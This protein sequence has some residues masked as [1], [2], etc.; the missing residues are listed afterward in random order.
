MPSM[1]ISGSLNV[2]SQQRQA[3]L[4]LVAF[5]LGFVFT[6][7]SINRG[8]AQSM[9]PM[10]PGYAGDAS[11]SNCHRKEALSYLHTAHRLTSQLPTLESVRGSFAAGANVLTIVAPNNASGEPSLQFRMDHEA[12]HFYETAITGFDTQLERQRE[13]IDIVTGSGKRGQTYL[14]WQGDQLFELPVSYWAAGRRWINSPGYDDGTANF[15]RAIY[16][17]C[18]ECHASYLRPLS[19]APDSNRFDRA[20]FEPGIGCETCH[21]PGAKHVA[22]ETEQVA[23]RSKLG[24]EVART[25]ILNPAKFSRDR[26]IDLCALCHHGIDREPLAP[27]FSYVPGEPLSKYF[28]PIETAAVEHP[29]VHGNQVGLLERSRC[30]RESSNMTC[31][32]CH[33]THAPERTA[34][35]YSDRCLSCHRWQGC[36]ESKHIGIGIKTRCID[37]HMPIEPTKVI[38]STTAGAEV[39]ATMRNHWIKVYPTSSRP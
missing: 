21:G 35:S 39:H 38:V 1:R 7:G 18:M 13:S 29:D 25:A 28:R 8:A 19:D 22:L 6:A 5:T 32:T 20:S 30:F 34:A 17:A 31:S 15:S 16:P 4:L 23:H 11:C 27:A 26:Q 12:G 36:P 37:C 33:D 9:A 3:L 10:R 14:Y 24:S 2:T